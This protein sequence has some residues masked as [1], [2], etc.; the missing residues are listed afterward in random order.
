M[1]RKARIA[2]V[3]AGWWAT[4]THLPALKANPRA[5]VAALCDPDPAR[6]AAA[7]AAYGIATTYGDLDTM[8]AA[9]GLDGAIIATPHATHHR[10]A[11]ACLE[12]GLHVVVEKPLTLYARDARELAELAARQGRQL[13]VGYP[14]HYAPHVL[15][16]RDALRSGELG[17]V[18]FVSCTFTSAIRGLLAGHDGSHQRA[19]PVHGPGAVYSK[20]ELSGGGMGHLQLTHSVGALSFIGG[21]RPRRVLALMRS[22]GLPLDMVD[23][24]TVEFAGGALGMVGGSGNGIHRK[25]DLQIHCER[26]AVE[27][28]LVR[29]TLTIRGPDDRLEEFRPLVDGEGYPKHAPADNLV[30][31]ICDG[32]PNASPPEAGLHTVEL[33]DAAYRSAAQEGKAVE[34]AS[35][36]E[37]EEP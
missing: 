19:Y 29:D 5:E 6:L 33:L 34:V 24:I 30:A 23:A 22:H 17:A 37:A 28:D 1:T 7:A 4:A 16:A 25:L 32:A 36:Y 26:G 31:I 20:P 14:W 18:E 9:E 10:L 8:L 35:L 21:L 27:L 2:V 13:I 11:R 15:R 3:G 12:R